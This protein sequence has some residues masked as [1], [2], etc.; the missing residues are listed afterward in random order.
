MMWLLCA[1]SRPRQS[2]HVECQAERQRGARML[3]VANGC[4]Y[5]GRAHHIITLPTRGAVAALNTGLEWLRARA[6]PSDWW[7]R[8]DDDDEYLDGYADEVQR[9]ASTGADFSG[10][11][12]TRTRL[13]DGSDVMFGAPT[14]QHCS[15]GTLAARLGSTLDF[16]EVWPGE[17]YAWAQTMLAAGRTFAAHAGKYVRVRHADNT[18]HIT[19]AQLRLLGT[20]VQEKTS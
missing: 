11:P 9:V 6:R 15:G 3:V 20:A 2:A 14:S 17:D 4:E 10:L 13:T 7:A 12:V 18:S 19:D 16:P 8:V 1:F 5:H